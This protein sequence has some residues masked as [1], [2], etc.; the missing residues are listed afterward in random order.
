MYMKS[1][2]CALTLV[3]GLATAGLAEQLPAPSG[4]VL[5]TLSGALA[6]ETAEG[7]VSLD[8]EMLENMETVEFTTSTIWMEDEVTFTGVPLSDVLD[9]AGAQGDEI[10]AVALNDYKIEIPVSEIEE[11]S[12]II[13]YLMNGELMSRRNKWPL[14]ICYDYDSVAK[15]RSEV[16]YSR[17]IWQLDRIVSNN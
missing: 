17:S 6:N 8:R 15:Y 12:P 11:N 13:A 10:S 7:V 4:E 2:L 9:Y 3:S 14:C 1:T 16:I 5:L